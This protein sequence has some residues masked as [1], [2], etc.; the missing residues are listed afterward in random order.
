MDELQTVTESN[1]NPHIYNSLLTVS[2][3]S[4]MNPPRSRRC[5]AFHNTI[6]HTTVGFVSPPSCSALLIAST[7]MGCDDR[8]S[9][10]RRHRG[11]LT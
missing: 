2:V 3:L 11:E 5:T 10:D 1:V 9:A 7:V 4:Q 8:Y 6:V